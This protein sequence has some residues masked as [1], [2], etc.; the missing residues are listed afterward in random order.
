MKKKTS[1][2]GVFLFIVFCFIGAILIFCG[3]SSNRPLSPGNKYPPITVKFT[4]TGQADVTI[5]GSVQTVTLPYEKKLG[6]IQRG[7]TVS[8][9]TTNGGMFV[10]QYEIK[11]FGAY[12]PGCVSGGVQ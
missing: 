6:N 10:Y 9:C 12:Q 1:E 2:V 11:I 3:C 4:G 8:V 7:S 5:N